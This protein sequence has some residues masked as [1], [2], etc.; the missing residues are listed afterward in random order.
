MKGV[1]ADES[2]DSIT[3]QNMLIEIEAE[4]NRA[5]ETEVDK[6]ADVDQDSMITSGYVE[7]GDIL[8][9]DNS[10][11]ETEESEESEETVVEDATAEN[12]EIMSFDLSEVEC[13]IPEEDK[14][15]TGLKML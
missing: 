14:S 10:D 1:E 6:S 13:V 7:V 4:L 9:L 12:E 2:L 15:S 5:Q 8:P 3:L 11:D